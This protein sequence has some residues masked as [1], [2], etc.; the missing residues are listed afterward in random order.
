DVVRQVA[1]RLAQVLDVGGVTGDAGLE[2]GVHD[3]VGVGVRSHRAHFHAHALLISDG[4]ADHGSAIHRRSLEL[5]GRFKVRIETAVSI[6]A[7]VQHQ[8]DVIAVSENAID[9]LPSQLAEFLF[10]LGI[11][12]KVLAVFADGDVGMHAAAVHTHDGFGKETG[13]EPHLGG[14]LATDELVKLNL[15]GRGQN[16]S[17]AVIDF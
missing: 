4:Y 5:I 14:H 16:F 17:I 6:H 11:P 7:G 2:N 8:A 12:E 3:H 13:G 9:K 10:A 15:V 1:F